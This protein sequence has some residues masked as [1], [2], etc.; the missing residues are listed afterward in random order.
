LII[1]YPIE[2]SPLLLVRGAG[3]V[4]QRIAASLQRA[5]RR[6]TQM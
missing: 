4:L 2:K 1:V 6:C 5:A 3:D